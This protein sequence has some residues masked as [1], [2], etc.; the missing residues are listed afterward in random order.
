VAHQAGSTE[1]SFM[2]FTRQEQLDDAFTVDASLYKTI[3][4]QNDSQLWVTLHLSNLTACEVPSY[5][6]ESMRSQRYGTATATMRMPQATR[7]LY[8]APRALM[9]TVG[10]RF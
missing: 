1:E 8:G 4:F 3:Y 9:L 2:A 10:Y 5:G 6:Y 7:Y